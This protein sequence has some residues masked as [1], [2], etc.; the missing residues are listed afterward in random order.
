MNCSRRSRTPS[1]HASDTYT[2]KRRAALT[3]ALESLAGQKQ[4]LQRRLQ[5]PAGELVQQP[6]RA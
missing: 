3:A 4:L 2:P 1:H 6:A 5:C